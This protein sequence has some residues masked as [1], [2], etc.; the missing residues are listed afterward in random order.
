MIKSRFF[1]KGLA[2]FLSAVLITTTAFSTA[3]PVGAIASEEEEVSSQGDAGDME[4]EEPYDDKVYDDEDESSAQESQD[5]YDELT[6][7]SEASD[8]S[9]AAAEPAGEIPT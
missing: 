2:R 8:A 9:A 1:R 4:D 3:M 6:Q 5:A 7:D